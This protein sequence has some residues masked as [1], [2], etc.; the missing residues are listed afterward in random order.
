ME[1]LRVSRRRLAA[2]SCAML[3][4]TAAHPGPQGGQGSL[5]VSALVPRHATIRFAPPASITISEEDV[6]RGYHELAAA[7]DVAV[8]SNVPQ[9][10]TLVF[11]LDR[12]NVD[13][14]R[15]AGLQGALLVGSAGAIATRPATARGMW[16]DQLQLRIRFD[17]PGDAR[18]GPVAWPLRV[19]MMA[20]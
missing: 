8:Q 10:Y 9:G 2:A 5:L 6:A 11:E 20:N 17:L 19:L 15:V 3:F 13:A 7:V 4:A 1:S 16:R 14:A 18:P 12:A